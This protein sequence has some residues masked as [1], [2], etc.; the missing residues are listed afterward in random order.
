MHCICL[1]MAKNLQ[2]TPFNHSFNFFINIWMHL[3]AADTFI[4]EQNYLPTGLLLYDQ[5]Y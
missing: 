3:V 4:S 5:Y 2:I 1:A